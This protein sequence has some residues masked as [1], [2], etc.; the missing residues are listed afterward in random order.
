MIRKLMRKLKFKLIMWRFRVKMKRSYK[1]AIRLGVKSG[2]FIQTATG[3]NL[4]RIAYQH[5]ISRCGR[6][7]AEL[8]EAIV[9]EIKMQKGGALE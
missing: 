7:D 9:Q 3:D 2:R 6:T 8:R 1:A 4:D 5:G